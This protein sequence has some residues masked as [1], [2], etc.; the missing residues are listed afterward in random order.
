MH[1]IRRKRKTNDKE[2]YIT[3][4]FILRKLYNRTIWQTKN[5]RVIRNKWVGNIGW[6]FC[7]LLYFEFRSMGL[8]FRG[9]WPCYFEFINFEQSL[10]FL[11]ALPFQ[12]SFRQFF[13]L[14]LHLCKERFGIVKTLMDW[15]YELVAYV[16]TALWGFVHL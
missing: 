13:H 15:V 16:T 7:F 1:L 14:N 2:I 6:C 9:L 5:M 10:P 3:L 11:L 8:N 4:V 12:S